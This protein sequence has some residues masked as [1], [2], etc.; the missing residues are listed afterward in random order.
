MNESGTKTLK[1]MLIFKLL[2]KKEASGQVAI[3]YIV[4]MDIV[5][6][7]VFNIKFN[8]SLRMFSVR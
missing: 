5:Q 4:T 1:K 6:H 2:K 3:D 8:F 7:I